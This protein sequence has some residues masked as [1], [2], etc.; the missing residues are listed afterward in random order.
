MVILS[1]VGD[2]FINSEALRDFINLENLSVQIHRGECA[3]VFVSVC[4]CVCTEFSKKS[5]IRKSWVGFPPLWWVVIHIAPNAELV[6]NNCDA[7]PAQFLTSYANWPACS[8]RQ[9]NPPM[10]IH[11]LL[12]YLFSKTFLHCFNLSRI[13]YIMCISFLSQ[14]ILEYASLIEEPLFLYMV[15]LLCWPAYR[16]IDFL[17]GHR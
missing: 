7:T 15:Q 17:A 13:L 3:C 14:S 6:N 5:G 9:A 1:L 11:Y 10:C 2:M 4:I 12:G 8:W 16:S